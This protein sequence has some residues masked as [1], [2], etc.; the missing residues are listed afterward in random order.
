MTTTTTQQQQRAASPSAAPTQSRADGDSGDL[1]R[2]LAATDTTTEFSSDGAPAASTP[3][4]LIL[5]IAQGSGCPPDSTWKFLLSGRNDQ[6]DRRRKPT[7]TRHPPTLPQLFAVEPIMLG[8]D[9]AGRG[10]VMGPM[11]Y[12]IAFAPIS[13]IDVIRKTGVDDSKKLTEAD[14]DSLFARFTD[15]DHSEWMGWSVTAISPKEISEGMLRKSKYN[16]NQQAHDTTI[17][18][19]RNVIRRGVCVR[20]V[21]V[22][23]VGKEKPYQELLERHF[24]GIAITVASKADS[25]FPIVSAASIFAKVIRDCV[26]RR[27]RFT[28]DDFLRESIS[29]TFGSGYP[30]GA[31]TTIRL[32]I[33]QTIRP[34]HTKWLKENLDPV[35]G[36]PSIIRFSWSTAAKM[37]QDRGIPVHW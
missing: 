10:P 5:P 11:V 24:P 1:P 25:K 6:A 16:L 30:S 3:D 27:W 36:Y 37:M 35:F 15:E 28:E 18:L 23:T 17:D 20:E 32:I 12:A 26:V 4:D 21:Y 33:T 7:Q 2:D 9:E 22:D 14:R 13:R 8:V 19:I 31:T 29:R 34:K